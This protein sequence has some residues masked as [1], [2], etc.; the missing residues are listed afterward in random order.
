MTER[1]NTR[2]DRI[3]AL[4]PVEGITVADLAAILGVSHKSSEQRLRNYVTTGHLFAT[5]VGVALRIFPTAEARD[6]F[7]AAK[8]G[9]QPRKASA[10]D[11]SDAFTPEHVKPVE[12]P[13]SLGK[14]FQADPV[15][16]GFASLPIGVYALPA[17]SCA[18]KAA[19]EA[20]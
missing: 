12:L 8:A 14:R 2:R 4:V 16:G 5:K 9:T 10:W 17:A 15:A 6:A 18:A 7:R 11:R 19:S 1:T 20:A 3:V 13:C